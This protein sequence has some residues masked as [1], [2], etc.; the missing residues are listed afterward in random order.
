M[1]QTT[2]FFLSLLMLCAFQGS[3]QE[4]TVLEHKIDLPEDSEVINGS[5]Y[6]QSYRLLV[7][8][9]SEVNGRSRLHSDRT[10]TIRTYDAS[11]KSASTVDVK[12]DFS[13][14]RGCYFRAIKRA[15][16]NEEYERKIYSQGSGQVTFYN[17]CGG[18]LAGFVPEGGI[19]EYLDR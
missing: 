2:Y 1:K 7:S 17:I 5:H 3:A 18:L 19:Q 16:E 15:K 12:Y 10:M 13:P 6:G 4:Y 8:T 9:T 14:W 11:F